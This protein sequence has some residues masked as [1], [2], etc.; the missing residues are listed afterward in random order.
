MVTKGCD[1]VCGLVF[2]VGSSREPPRQARHRRGLAAPAAHPGRTKVGFGGRRVDRAGLDGRKGG[3][4]PA[5]QVGDRP[6]DR[7]QWVTRSVGRSRRGGRCDRRTVHGHAPLGGLP[8]EPMD[9]DQIAR[10]NLF[11]SPHTSFRVPRSDGHRTVDESRLVRPAA[12]AGLRGDDSDHFVERG[13]DPGRR[14]AVDHLATPAR[15]RGPGAAST[16]QRVGQSLLASYSSGGARRTGRAGAARHRGGRDGLGYPRDQGIRSRKGS[17]REVESRSRRHPAR[18]DE[19]G[20]YPQQFPAGHRHPSVARLD[21][22]TRY[23]RPSCDRR[24][25]DRRRPRE[26]Q[27]LHHD[28]D[29]A[30]AQHRHD[31]RARP[32]RCS[33][34]HARE[35]GALHPECDRRSAHTQTTASR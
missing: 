34:P 29:L 21:R 16:R 33:R 4:T 26:V 3:G 1:T 23:G 30:V 19:G 28:A 27:R 18:I 5:H 24:F 6:R 32:A 8:R 14:R 15:H 25:D 22:R 10:A 2:S 7:R 35:R 11:A 9:R 31:G 17:G 12:V 13:D 20:S